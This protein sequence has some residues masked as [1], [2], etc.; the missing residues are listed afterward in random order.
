MKIRF[1]VAAAL[2]LALVPALASATEQVNPRVLKVKPS[3]YYTSFQSPK[4]A[5]TVGHGVELDGTKLREAVGANAGVKITNVKVVASTPTESGAW[6]E[7][8]IHVDP[9]ARDF[10]HGATI[11]FAET[12]PVAPG[13]FAAL[14]PQLD[15]HGAAYRAEVTTSNGATTV[16]H[17]QGFGANV[18]PNNRGWVRR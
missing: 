10:E 5:N 18:L 16:I 12:F 7:D 17:L 2:S 9:T 14:K 11:S 8:E 15:Q 4:R 3:L 1:M 6:R 13:H